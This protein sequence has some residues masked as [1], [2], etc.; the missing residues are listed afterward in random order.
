MHDIIRIKNFSLSFPSKVCFEDFSTEISFGDRIAIIGR[1]GIGK[2]SLLKMIAEK[3]RNISLAYI[4]QI[5]EDF[6]SLSGGERFN[7]SLSYAIGENPSILLLDEPTNHLDIDNRKSLMRMLNSY[8]GT[9]IAVTHDEELL[10]NCCD[11]LWHIDNGKITIFRGKYTDYI[12]EREKQYQSASHQMHL[13]ELE[14][15]SMHKKLMKEQQKA[16]KSKASG[17]KKIA[18]KKWMKSVADLK[19]MNAEKSQ[20]KNLKNL[21]E[22]KQKLAEQ[23]NEMQMPEIIVPKFHL[24][25]Q[26]IGD[27]TIVSVVDGAIGYSKENFIAIHINFSVMSREHIAIIGKNGTGKTTLLK[28]LMSDPSVLKKGD[29][30]VPKLS[31]IGYLDQHYSNLD[32]E[33]SA[34]EIIAEANPSWTHAEIRRHLNDFLFRKNE[35]VNNAVKNLSGGEKARLSLAQIAAN[36]PKLLILDEITNNIDLETKNHLTEILREYPAAMIIVSHDPAFLE[37]IR[38][39]TYIGIPS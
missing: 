34:I 22:K 23:L 10:Q 27:E 9:L 38:I 2:S 33:K 21:D 14:K 1:N 18:D 3:N 17:K 31:E 11:I 6:D 30:Y 29:W 16:A 19:A 28:A 24:P 39:D 4:P 8:Y 32:S 25:F 36:V 26:K 37:K 15:K 12:K 13:L 5:I 7:K 35:E 20:G